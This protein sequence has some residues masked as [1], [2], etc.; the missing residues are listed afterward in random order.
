[1]GKSKASKSAKEL[2]AKNRGINLLAAAR[3]S[4]FGARDAWILTAH[5]C[6]ATNGATCEIASPPG[7][8]TC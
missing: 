7:C 8:T 6:Q 3:A 1:M 2:F 5:C 4:L